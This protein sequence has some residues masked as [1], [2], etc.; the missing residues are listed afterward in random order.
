[1]T[2]SAIAL[3]PSVDARGPA[4]RLDNRPEIEYSPSTNA[5]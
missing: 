3:A 5:G 2:F 4:V 1:M